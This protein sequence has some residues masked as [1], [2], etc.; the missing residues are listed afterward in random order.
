VLGTAGHV[1]RAPTRPTRDIL[2][3][4]A[5]TLGVKLRISAMPACER[6]IAPFLREPVEMR[7]RVTALLS[8]RRPV[9]LHVVDGRDVV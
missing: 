2:A 3:I 4:A 1:P 9:R 7:L 6:Y 5:D 8:R